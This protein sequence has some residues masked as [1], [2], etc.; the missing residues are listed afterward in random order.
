MIVYFEYN[1]Y[2][3]HTHIHKLKISVLLCYVSKEFL[4]WWMKFLVTFEKTYACD[5]Y[6]ST[7]VLMYICMSV[8]LHT[9]QKIL[10]IKVYFKKFLSFD[11][12][13]RMF[14]SLNISHTVHLFQ[15]II[16][17]LYSLSYAVCYICLLA[18]C[19]DLYF[20]YL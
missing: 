3:R 4:K 8:L 17:L 7:F 15:I 1:A 11:D 10:Y 2:Y 9:V 5:K 12:V 18:I 13:S 16:H 6:L 14:L 20:F 19:T